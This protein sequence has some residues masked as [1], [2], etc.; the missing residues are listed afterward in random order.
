MRKIKLLI[1]ILLVISLLVNIGMFVHFRSKIIL[2]N[3]MIDSLN[4]R[5]E[6]DSLILADFVYRRNTFDFKYIQAK[7][8]AKNSVVKLGEPLEIQTHLVT[9]EMVSEDRFFGKPYLVIGSKLDTV[10]LSIIGA[11]DTIRQ[12]VWDPK[13]TKIPVSIGNDTVFGLYCIPD[14]I[15]GNTLRFPFEIPYRVVGN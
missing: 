2:S 1:V 11:A 8:F 9:F 3:D 12:Y 6:K 14:T 7:G 15:S 13:F 10:G 4:T 5:I